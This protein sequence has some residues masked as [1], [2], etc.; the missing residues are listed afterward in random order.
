MRVCGIEIKGSEAILCLMA[1]KDGLFDLPECRQTRL[2][3]T[4]DKDAESLQK[5]QFNLAKLVEDYKIEQLVIKERPQKGKFAGGAV[6]FKIEA[7]IQLINKCPSQI[8]SAN[9]I[10]EK[11]KQHPLPV[12]F[13]D[14]GL[15]GFQETAFTIAY[16]FLAK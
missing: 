11:L 15:K 8:L 16:A 10:K 5:F 13:K 14:T 12:D 7:A 3:L 9:A 2:A 4:N 1:F 6:G